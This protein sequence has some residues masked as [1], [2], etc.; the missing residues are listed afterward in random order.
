VTAQS[1]RVEAT[2]RRLELPVES[3]L[4]FDDN[5]ELKGDARVVLVDKM[6]A[7]PTD[8]RAAVLALMEREAPVEGLEPDLVDFLMEAPH[9]DCSLRRDG[10]GQ[11]SWYIPLSLASMPWQTPE[12]LIAPDQERCAAAALPGTSKRAA[13]DAFELEHQISDCSDSPLEARDAIANL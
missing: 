1:K 7:M 12:P 3:A 8:K 11:L 4:L 10:S 6:T 13:G 2:A 5:V 9:G